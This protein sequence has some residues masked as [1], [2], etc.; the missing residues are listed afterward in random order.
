MK[1]NNMSN[2]LAT[3]HNIV[4]KLSEADLYDA[5]KGGSR[6]ILPISALFE[7]GKRDASGLNKQ[8]ISGLTESDDDDV[9]AAAA[10]TLGKENKPAHRKA[11][12]AALKD[13]AP[14]VVRRA[15]EAL[16][17]I[18][19]SK[20]LAALRA[21]Q[22]EHPLVKRAVDTAK[23]LLAYSLGQCE[24][25]LAP[26][27]AQQILRL[28]HHKSSEIEVKSVSIK[29]KKYSAMLSQKLPQCTLAEQA[30]TIDC[31][32]WQ[33]LLV[34]ENETLAKITKQQASHNNA[35][36]LIAQFKN[37]HLFGVL[38]RCEKADAEYYRYAHILTHA[39][40]PETLHLFAMR[41]ASVSEIAY[42]GEIIFSAKGISFSIHA[43]NTRHTRPIVFAGE[44]EAKT[45]R[46]VIS[47]AA[48]ANQKAE[49]QPV[50]NQP[51]QIKMSVR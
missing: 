36:N 21:L 25:L 7:L 12:A 40:S 6:N 10:L 23:T 27:E 29:Q 14:T 35:S 49:R 33:Y 31:G 13:G 43:L 34:F 42:Y 28:G 39:K 20:E 41:D 46:I 44:I 24:G 17:R 19:T 38:L 48:V 4:A 45:S 5:M 18:G 30:L 3:T 11:L 50:Q 1:S 22:P 32:R 8:L 51:R 15:A 47:R 9:R 26:P 2:Y 16:G 37:G